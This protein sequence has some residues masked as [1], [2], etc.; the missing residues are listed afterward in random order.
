MMRR[1]T[2]TKRAS[3]LSFYVPG[4]ERQTRNRNCLKAKNYLM[5]FCC[6]VTKL[7]NIQVIESRNTQSVM[8]GLTRLGYEQGFPSQLILDQESSFKKI[9][10]E[11]EIDLQD[12]NLRSWREYGVSF[13][14]APV[15]AHNYIGLLERKIRT[16]QDCFVKIDLKSQRL[17]ATGLQTLAKLVENHLNNLPLGYSFGPDSNNTPLL[18]L[19][20][21]NMLRVGR[22]NSR[23]LAGSIKL[24]KGPKDMMNKVEKLYNAFFKMWNI[25]MIPR[26]I[27]QPKWFKS[28]PDIKVDDV[29]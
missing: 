6:C 1:R 13:K 11:A 2:S 4:Y 28:S 29:V 19:I 17:H 23:A 16:V 27:A 3:S 7:I 14:F 18:R 20:M 26:L 8:E 10:Q 22:L 12:L 9:V 21:P 15:G 25:V 5:V 24:P